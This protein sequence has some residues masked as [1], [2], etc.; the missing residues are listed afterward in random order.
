LEGNTGEAT[1]QVGWA[2]LSAFATGDSGEQIRL[3]SMLGNGYNEVHRFKEA[4]GF[5]DR[6]LVTVEKTKDAGIP[7][8]AYEGKAVALIGL[9]QSAQ[10]LR[11]LE[12]VLA[13]ARGLNRPMEQA[14]ILVLLG[15]ANGMAGDIQLAK[16]QYQEAARISGQE[17]YYRPLARAMFE[18][19]NM[20]REAGDFRAADRALTV[21]VKASQ[22]LGDRYY[23]PRDL[24][25]LA[26]VKAAENRIPE[27]DALFAYAEDV[28][29]A[30][31]VAAHSRVAVRAMAQSM[32][33][34]YFKHFELLETHHD[35]SRALWVVERL[36][37]RTAAVNLFKSDTP[38]VRAGAASLETDIA[39]LQ[40]ALLKTEDE[41][42]RSSLLDQL[43][44]L[45]RNL[46][47]EENESDDGQNEKELPAASLSR[48]RAALRT[49]EQLVEYVLLSPRSYCI[50]V[51]RESANIVMLSEGRESLTDLIDSYKKELKSKKQATDL[52]SRLYSILL[53]PV[54]RP[55][56]PRLIVSAEGELKNLPFESL[57]V[58]SGQYLVAREVVTYI[59]SATTLWWQRITK[60]ATEPK[61]SLLAVGDVS[62]RAD[63]QHGFM[64][65]IR[66][67]IESLSQSKMMDLPGTR[68]E[69]L[70]VAQVVG[71]DAKILLAHDATEAAF[72]AQPLEEFRIIHL[73]VHA[74]ADSHYPER[75][76]LLLGADAVSSDDGLL[77]VREILRLRLNSELVT[78]S[79]CETGIAGE[80]GVFSLQESFLIAGARTV[81]ASLW[82]VEDHSTTV[83]M[84]QFYRHLAEG[85]DKANALAHAKQDFI[86]QYG[87]VSPF[88]WAGFVMAG[89][90]LARLSDRRSIE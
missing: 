12:N 36:R 55:Q 80:A 19:A 51:T 46:A 28:L 53:A 10:G 39:K 14:E 48:L 65:A 64:A 9:G 40:R 44:Q 68:D 21:G 56:K 1:S 11:L 42:L 30:L 73:A 60:S 78:L 4:L 58:P 18:L 37:S 81:V 17:L 16:Q 90:G 38:A 35:V 89:D 50:V 45:E 70:T 3:L 47:Y 57:I 26:E 24:A 66:R 77:Q 86:L 74:L 23:L 31:F 87:P 6:A 63:R 49:D 79:A 54:L 76:A 2:L 33:D 75:T 32:S 29:D 62:Y 8:M 43:L 13:K 52:A 84:Q 83:L 59:P 22:R 27:A 67:G 61:Y 20:Y 5:F 69:V 88:Y 7:W 82:N 34:V 71:G 72:K 25:V 41:Q 15:H 85:E